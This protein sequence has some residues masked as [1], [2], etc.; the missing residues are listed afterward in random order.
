MPGRASAPVFMPAPAS[1]PAPPP[2]SAPASMPAPAS[3]SA[4]TSMS[5]PAS[6]SAPVS[7]PAPAVTVDGVE[8]L[9]QY[10]PLPPLPPY[11]RAAKTSEQR[12]VEMRDLE[13]GESSG[14]TASHSRDPPGYYQAAA[15]TSYSDERVSLGRVDTDGSHVGA[16][17]PPPAPAVWYV[18]RTFGG[19]GPFSR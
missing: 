17:P 9:P 12:P 15:D 18:R 10:E 16:P 6:M 4:P 3:M 13:R 5:A 8:Q 2:I 1:M 11:E 7:M 19:F 14:T